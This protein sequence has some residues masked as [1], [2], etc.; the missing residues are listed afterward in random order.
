[1]SLLRLLH[2]LTLSYSKETSLT[3]TVV[4]G[5][6]TGIEVN[7]SKTKGCVLVLVEVKVAAKAV[8]VQDRP[9]HPTSEL[10]PLLFPYNYQVPFKPISNFSSPPSYPYCR[11]IHSCVCQGHK[12][13]CSNLFSRFLPEGSRIREKKRRCANNRQGLMR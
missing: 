9:G 12:E 6:G 4:H 2:I 11:T 1:M 8:Q 5:L 3:A 7:T 13:I 10:P